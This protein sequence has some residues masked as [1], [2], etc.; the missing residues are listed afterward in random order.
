M[1][2][3]ALALGLVVLE[4]TETITVADGTVLIFGTGFVTSGSSKIFVAFA[5]SSAIIRV[6][7]ALS[8]STAQA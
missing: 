7:G 1:T 5:D 2:R 8:M 4:R 3:V 6:E